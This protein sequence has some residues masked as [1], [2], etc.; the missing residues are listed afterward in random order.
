MQQKIIANTLLEEKQESFLVENRIFNSEESYKELFRRVCSTLK[1]SRFEIKD[2]VY[3]FPDFHELDDRSIFE[4]L[5][6]AIFTAQAKWENYERNLDK[7][8]KLLFNYDFKKIENLSEE[9]IER[10]YEEMIKMK[11]RDRFLHRK[12]KYFRKNA[13]LFT[14]LQGKRTSMHEFL[15][16]GL[17]DKET[18]INKLTSNG[19]HHKLKGVRLAICCEFFKNIGVDDFKPDVH[20]VYLFSRLRIVNIKNPKSPTARELYSIRVVGMDIAKSNNL[21]FHVVDNVLW[22]FCAE[23]KGEICT[24]KSPKCSKCRL[25]IEEPAMCGGNFTPNHKNCK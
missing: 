25:R 2:A 5:C 1:D 15:K 13:R 19:S 6:K 10:I 18:L 16:K 17:S 4:G 21:P 22:F 20:M 12:L 23:G 24:T 7:I 14:N 11:V 3:P 9:D 8:D